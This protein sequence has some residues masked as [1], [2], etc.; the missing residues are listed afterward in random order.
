MS[1]A[2]LVLVLVPQTFAGILLHS[3]ASVGVKRLCKLAI[4]FLT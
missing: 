1:N 3:A 2:V 4:R